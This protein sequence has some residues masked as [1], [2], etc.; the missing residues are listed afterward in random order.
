MSKRFLFIAIL[1]GF[2]VTAFADPEIYVPEQSWDF[3]HIP[4]QSTVS[5]EYWIM[6]VGTDT[7]KIVKVKPG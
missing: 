4:Q 6:N 1:L 3:G 2:A 5:H 7:L